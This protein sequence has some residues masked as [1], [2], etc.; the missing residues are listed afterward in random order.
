MFDIDIVVLWVDGSD[1]EWLREKNRYM[2]AKVEQ[3]VN[4]SNRFRDWDLMHYWFRAVDKYMPWIRNTHFVTW[5]HL[6]K[7]L[8]TEHPK[9][10]I[11][12]HT[13]FMPEGSLP[14]FSSTALEINI[15]RI[16]GLAEHFIYFNDDLFPVRPLRPDDFFD[17]KTGLPRYR[18]LEIPLRFVGTPTWEY[19]A[20]NN[21]GILNKHFNKKAVP[22]TAYPGKYLSRRYGL[23]ANLRSLAAKLVYPE[24]YVGLKTYHGTSAFLRSTFEELWEREGEML[25]QQTHRRFRDQKEVNQW[26]FVWWQLL[27]GNF[28]PGKDLNMLFL[29]SA[30][31]I[32]TIRDVIMNRKAGTVCI[33]DP[34]SEDEEEISYLASRIREAFESV[35]PDRSG[36]EK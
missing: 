19:T 2:H 34:D 13:D 14:T 17:L 35:L 16:S 20:A 22:L 33:N 3:S 11:V 30:E 8:N 23:K 25:M 31:S 24:Y 7:F 21:M 9:L 5:G 32:D 29:A 27:S 36:F 10:H 28:A 15:H 26:L 1:P 4:G 18:Y 12:N 6:P